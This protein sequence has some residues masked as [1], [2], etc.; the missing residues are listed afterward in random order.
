MLKYKP[1]RCRG[2]NVLVGIPK[3]K[4]VC[5]RPG[6][7]WVLTEWLKTKDEKEPLFLHG[8]SG[9]GSEAKSLGTFNVVSSYTLAEY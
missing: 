6:A 7:Q 1:D 8:N 3:T 5:N 2:F 9:S 4:T